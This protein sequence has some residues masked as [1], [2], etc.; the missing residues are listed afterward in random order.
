M[1]VIL[2]DAEGEL[3]LNNAMARRHTRAPGRPRPIHDQTWDHASRELGT[4]RPLDVQETALGLALAGET[5]RDFQFMLRWPGTNRDVWMC[6]DAAPVKNEAGSIVGASLVIYGRAARAPDHAG[7][8]SLSL[9]DS[10]VLS[11]LAAG[12]T[13]REIATRLAL[14]ENT[15]KKYVSNLLF[16]HGL[17]R[18]SEVAAYV[19]LEL[20]ESMVDR[21]ELLNHELN[22]RERRIVWLMAQGFTNRRISA[23]LELS[24]RAVRR[25]VSAILDKLQ[26]RSRAQAVALAVGLAGAADEEAPD[27]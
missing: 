16:R 21:L 12:K 1:G 23:E 8:A 24:E 9:R 2:V 5:V 4:G 22:Q 18:R 15:V 7:R 25:A 14:S 10:Q 17:A 13:N 6:V 3:V 26:V 27:R 19:R 11:L 20:N